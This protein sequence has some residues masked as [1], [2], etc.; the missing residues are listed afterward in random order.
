MSVVHV[1]NT[2][3]SFICILVISECSDISMLVFQS[4]LL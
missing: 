2:S 4:M 3:D 1:E